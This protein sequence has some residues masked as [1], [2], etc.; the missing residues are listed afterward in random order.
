MGRLTH[1][2]GGDL[3]AE[4]ARRKQDLGRRAAAV[5]QSQQ[6]AASEGPEEPGKGHQQEPAHPAHEDACPLR[7]RTQ[8]QSH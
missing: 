5:A 8:E 7:G 1:M 3:G 6:A 4:Q 2:E